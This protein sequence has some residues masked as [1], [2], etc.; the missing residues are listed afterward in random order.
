MNAALRKALFGLPL[1]AALALGVTPADAGPSPVA[2]RL[3]RTGDTEIYAVAV[4]GASIK[5]GAARLH[6]AA[7][8]DAAKR[9]A[10]DYAHYSSFIRQFEQSRIVGKHGEQTDVYLRVPILKGAA[11]IWAV[12]RFGPPRQVSADEYVI[13]GKMV[14]GNVK[15]F[16]AK[17]RI[18]R[19]DAQNTQLN[20][21]M[22]IVPRLP[23]PGSVVTGEVSR[24]CRSAVRQIRD[25]AEGKS[26]SGQGK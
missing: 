26:P 3:M 11:K 19:I 17:Y 4:P 16:D 5:A 10:S 23:F 20:L 6:I 24:A 18:T 13:E 15:R 7:P 8:A 12:M 25:A 9:L 22:L 1:A 2:Q 14:R 21:E